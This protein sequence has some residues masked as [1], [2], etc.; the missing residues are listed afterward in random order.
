MFHCWQ[1]TQGLKSSNVLQTSEIFTSIVY[2]EICTVSR[3]G[4]S[5]LNFYSDFLCPH[6]GRSSFSFFCVSPEWRLN[7][8]R[9]MFSP[10]GSQL[11]LRRTVPCF[12]HVFDLRSWYFTWYESLL[13]QGKMERIEKRNKKE[14]GML[15]TERERIDRGLRS[16][17]I[18]V[19]LLVCRA[20]T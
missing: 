4:M 15:E 12:I 16:T 18:N 5:E 9:G 3:T 1:A 6:R 19:K 13:K 2:V 7:L 10:T 11:A 17:G 8:L 14:K 20:G